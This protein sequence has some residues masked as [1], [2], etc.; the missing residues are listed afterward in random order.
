[1]TAAAPA[2]DAA[3]SGAPVGAIPVS[4]IICAYTED[5]WPILADGVDAARKQLR[6]GDELIVV[7]DHNERLRA[8]CAEAFADFAGVR[9]MANEQRRGPSGARNTAMPTASGSIMVFLDDDAIPLD[10]WLDAMR[11]PYADP[12]VYG[13][14]GVAHPRWPGHPPRWFPE[15]FFWVV[16]CSHRG[17]PRSAQP[18]RNLLGA[19]MSFRAEAF[20]LAGTFD[21]AL[22]RRPEKP[23]GGEETEFCIR[24]TRDHPGSV[25]RF[26]PAVQ[27]EHVVSRDRI[28]LRYFVHRCW[29]EGTSKAEVTR[30][31]GP[32][33]ALSTERQYTTRV[34]P[35]AVLRGLADGVRGDRWGAARAGTVALGLAVTVAG[36][37]A[38]TVRGPESGGGR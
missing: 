6:A 11:A 18:V 23:L 27:V 38:G 25:V 5:R 9:V 20:G 2:S 3:A 30:R 17:L 26:D 15:E 8:R 13:V 33:Q 24:L 37:A 35:R 28:R 22:G 31:V 32:G 16:G 1:V 4:V 10:G 36:Y 14:G 34:L 7:A 29:S 12:A 21:E 19:T